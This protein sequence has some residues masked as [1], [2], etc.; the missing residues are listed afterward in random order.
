MVLARRLPLLAVLLGSLLVWASAPVHAATVTA[1]LL[2]GQLTITDAPSTVDFVASSTSEDAQT[3]ATQ[4]VIGV[5]DA[6]GSKDGWS[7]KARF[8]T[9]ARENGV[10]LPVRQSRIIGADVTPETGLAPSSLLDYPRPF[11]TTGD[12]IFSAAPD[13]GMGKSWLTFGA[14][15]IL[16]ADAIDSGPFT[17]AL[18]VTIASGP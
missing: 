18:A 6:T 14:E 2:P 10:S 7:I 3:F 9:V 5:T 15:L 8:I 4:F 12:T 1:V 11:Q 13:S 17:T 16:P